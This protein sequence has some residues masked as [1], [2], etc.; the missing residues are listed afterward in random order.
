MSASEK[1]P[2]GIPGLDH[3]LEG[4]IVRGNSLLL[5]GPPGSGK[6]TFGIRMLYE[7]VVQYDEPGLLITFEEFPRQI[8]QEA[9]AYGV[10]LRALEESGKLRVIWTPPQKVMQAFTGKNDLLEKIIEEMNVKRLVI[11]SITHFKRVA[12]SEIEMR[13]SLAKI[14]NYL[15]LKGVN[16]ILVKELERMDSSTIAFEEYLVDASM[17]VYNLSSQT[18]GSN[19]RLVEVRKT[20]GQGHVSGRHPFKL[21]CTGLRV[22]PYLQPDDVRSFFPPA[23]P[24]KARRIPTGITG[25]DAMLAEG[26]WQDTL[27][28]VVGY[29]GT[30]KSVIGYHFIQAGLKEGERCLLVSLKSSPEQILT[31]AQSLTMRWHEALDKESLDIMHFSRTNLC[32]EEIM[33]QL[34]KHIRACKPQRLVFDS[35]D[36]LWTASRD[37][38]Q[39]RNFLTILGSVCEYAGITT[40]VTN[41]TQTMGGM[42]SDQQDYTSLAN[43]VI[44]LSLAESDGQLRRFIGVRKHVG[45]DHAKELREFQIDQFGLRVERKASGLSGILTGQTQGALSQVADE[46]LPSLD[47]LSE[48]LQSAADS[49]ETP[50][51]VRG[52]LRSAR[53]N[54]G[55]IDVLLREHFGVTTF[56]SLAEDTAPPQLR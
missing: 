21:G 40:L 13:E 11:D 55:F 50:D 31:Q 33:D 48:I 6:S 30:G 12:S 23:G 53:M 36:D 49:S 10:D 5:E 52:R 1:M 44:Q 39:M 3:L 54:L 9:S 43:C 20:R 4:G 37:T 29:P 28:L 41:Q 24:R 16:A 35:A 45:S 14:L 51:S 46:V 17:R 42:T 26:F 32:A 15:K 2:T 47:E 27:N 34:I 19:T 38:E 56:H 8:Y 7:G 22:F 18:T 25:L